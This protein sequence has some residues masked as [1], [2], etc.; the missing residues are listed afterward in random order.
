MYLLDTNHVSAMLEEHP[1]LTRRLAAQPDSELGIGMPSLAELWFMVYNSRRL[2]ENARELE[3]V[4]DELSLWDFGEE[5]A[6]EFGRIKAD[7]R[8]MGRP[9][10]D[11]D[12]QIAAIAR[13]NGLIVLTADAHF[14]YV[15]GL[16]VENWLV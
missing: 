14:S 7:L 3:T 1:V 8:R 13:L 5:A 9:I 10:P 15:P 4:L 12:A 2:E 16:S 6:K 11:V